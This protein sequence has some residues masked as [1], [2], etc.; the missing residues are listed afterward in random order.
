ML[1]AHARAELTMR[2]RSGQ[3]VVNGLSVTPRFIGYGL[4]NTVDYV[5][6]DPAVLAVSCERIK[7][8]LLSA[9]DIAD[10]WRG[11]VNV[12]I[13]AVRL[14]NEPVRFTSIRY[15]DGWAYGLEVPDWILRSRLVMA[16]V[17]AVLTELA[18]RQSTERTAELPTWLLEGMTAYLLANNPD[19]LT[20]EPTTR[21]MK[22]HGTEESL[23][24]IRQF[25]RTRSALTL[26]QLSWPKADID[27]VY[28]HCAHLFVHELLSLRGGRRSMAKMVARLTEN[29]NWQTTFLAAFNVHFRG[30]TDVDK[31]WALT[32]AHFTGRDPMSLW[33]LGEALA[34]LDEALVTPVQ[35]RGKNSTLPGTTHV[36][37][38]AIMAEWDERR[39]ESLLAEKVTHLQA[40]RLRSPPEALETIDGYMLALQSRLRKR[41]SK[42]DTIRRLNALDVQRL[43]LSPPRAAQ[44]DR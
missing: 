34:H 25:L 36:K 7:E 27:P 3:F 15:K 29:Y 10:A 33:P 8:T 39:Q 41:V 6:L 11:Q 17:Q 40:L 19:D 13:F 30:L 24:P 16:V 26:D 2:S 23:E 9:L 5:R 20:L 28:T 32:V 14:D 1:C 21:T 4:T 42:V 37:L 44:V 18:N 38:Q 35:V 43:K 31:W 22:R 12:R